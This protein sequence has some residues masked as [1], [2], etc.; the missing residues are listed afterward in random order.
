M[1]E[2][3]S[4]EASE[5]MSEEGPK[6][7]PKEGSKE[8]SDKASEKAFNE[9]FKEYIQVLFDEALNCI[10]ARSG[11]QIEKN[12]AYLSIFQKILSFIHAKAEE[13]EDFEPFCYRANETFN[14]LL[15]E[16][17]SLIHI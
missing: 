17:L 4:E 6:E 11:P 16:H 2:E 10:P 9:A 7:G 5:E 13:T 3:V 1:S 14:F 12:F 8:G 15:F